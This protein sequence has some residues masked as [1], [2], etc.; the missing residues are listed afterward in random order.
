MLALFSS[1]CNQGAEELFPSLLFVQIIDSIEVSSISPTVT[2][3][4]QRVFR[5]PSGC[6]DLIPVIHSGGLPT[7]PLIPLKSGRV[8]LSGAQSTNTQRQ[9][10][11]RFRRSS[12][13]LSFVFYLIPMEIRDGCAVA[14]L[15]DVVGSN[16][17]M[18]S[19]SRLKSEREALFP[20]SSKEA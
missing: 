10:E 19:I 14:T 4:R 18:H 3:S 16:V 5:K 8:L 9:K 13:R 17:P 15:E 12:L 20:H 6:N 11:D 1:R 2:H 7:L